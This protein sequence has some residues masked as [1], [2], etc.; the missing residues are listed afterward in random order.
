MMEILNNY[1]GLFAL[2]AFLATVI[3]PFYIYRKQK[4]DERQ[5]MQDEYDA[6]SETERFPM[7]IDEREYYAKRRKLA[8]GLKRK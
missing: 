5:A 1:S 6:I 2:L 4:R 8:K 3:V 7:S